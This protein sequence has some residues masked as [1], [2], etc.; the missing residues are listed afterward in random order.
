M[1]NTIE[2]N[3]NID[4]S[5]FSVVTVAFCN[6]LETKNVMDK[7]AKQLKKGLA[8]KSEENFEYD[9][10]TMTFNEYCPGGSEKFDVKRLYCTHITK[11][12]MNLIFR[13][14]L[15]IQPNVL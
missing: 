10:I 15:L 11:T 13:N 9:N 14:Y 12:E 8:D 5:D 4:I 1:C 3:K 6:I 2:N 7:V